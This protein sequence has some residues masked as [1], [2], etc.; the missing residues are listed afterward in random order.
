MLASTYR[1]PRGL[2]FQGVLERALQVHPYYADTSP[3][4]A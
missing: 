2:E 4:E 3:S 1:H